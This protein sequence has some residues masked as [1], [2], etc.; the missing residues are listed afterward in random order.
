MGGQ[1]ERGLFE[2]PVPGARVA[3]LETSRSN[4]LDDFSLPEEAWRVAA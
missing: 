3:L 4:R 1:A 2:M